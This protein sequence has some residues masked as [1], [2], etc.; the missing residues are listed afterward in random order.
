[1]TIPVTNVESTQTFGAWLSTTN[2]M[3][4]LFTQNTVTSDG[5]TGGSITGG[6]S[7]GNGYL[8]AGYL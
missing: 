2:R 8:G 3:A 5:T 7:Y 6:N 4:R 1:M